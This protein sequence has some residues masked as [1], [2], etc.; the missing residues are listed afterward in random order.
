MH[1][2]AVIEIPVPVLSR[3]L[4]IACLSVHH[5]ANEKV[6]LDSHLKNCPQ[7][8]LHSVFI[9]SKHTL[10]TSAV[11]SEITTALTNLRHSCPT[12]SRE[13]R[14]IGLNSKCS[15]AQ[16]SCILQGLPHSVKSSP[17]KSSDSPTFAALLRS[18]SL[19]RRFL[20]WPPE[21]ETLVS[22]C[23]PVGVQLVSCCSM[24]WK[25]L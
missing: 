8:C 18:T 15:L 7:D 10:V 9:F 17:V 25:W 13:S 4:F 22:R 12:W 19:W 24:V 14:P 16:F 23:C 6:L 3:F 20:K 1:S 11:A 21:H 2:R 5:C